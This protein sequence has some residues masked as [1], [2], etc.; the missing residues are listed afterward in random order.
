[1]TVAARC[2][3]RITEEEIWEALK[4]AGKDKTPEVT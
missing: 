4:N 3:G 2:E 1:M